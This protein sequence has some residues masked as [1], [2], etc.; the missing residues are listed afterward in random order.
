MGIENKV[1]SR[2]MDTMCTFNLIRFITLYM[3]GVFFN[4]FSIDKFVKFVQ[5]KYGLLFGI[6]FISSK[7]V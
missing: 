6:F 3:H 1:L 5:N 4:V 2:S 7:N